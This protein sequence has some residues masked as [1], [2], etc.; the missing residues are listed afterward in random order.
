MFATSISLVLAALAQQLPGPAGPA[1]SPGDGHQ[2]MAAAHQ[3]ASKDSLN[4]RVCLTER[5]SGR[6]VCRTMDAWRIEAQ[7]LEA[8]QP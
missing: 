7:R 4:R 6:Q 5:A 3:P 8:Q 1:L 2:G